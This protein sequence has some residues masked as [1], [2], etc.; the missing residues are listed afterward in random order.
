METLFSRYRNITILVAVLFAQVLTL[1]V[2][3]RRP[4][5]AGEGKPVRLI[6]VWAVTLVTPLEKGVVGANNFFGGLWHNYFWLRGVRKENAELRE[7]M[8]RMRLEEIRLV[9]DAAQ[10]RRLQLLLS[11]K[12]QFVSQT[13]A[14]QV[15]GTGG[16]ELSRT[17][18]IDKGRD[19]GL[20]SDM[21]VIAPEGIVGKIIKVYSGSSLVLLINDAS[22]GAGAILS[23]SRLQAI[24]NGTPSG[25]LQL[26][27]VMADEKIEVGDAVITSGG[28][29]VFPKGLPIGTVTQVSQGPDFFL[30]IHVKPAA[31]IARLEEVLVITKII[32]KPVDPNTVPSGPIRA[33]DILAERLPTLA[34][35]ASNINSTGIPLTTAEL[36]ARERAAK[37]AAAAVTTPTTTAPTGSAAAAPPQTKPANSAASPPPAASGTTPA[38]PKVAPKTAPKS[39]TASPTPAAEPPAQ[40]PPPA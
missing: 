15:I 25:E 11:F 16:S 35:G 21:A 23:R 19:D 30:N 22:S 29:R 7:Q 40:Q 17:V 5:E 26:H 27:N 2:Q 13:V 18:Y 24:L 38:K 4:P 12:E 34:P 14:A 1:A 28:D 9:Q 6:R 31:Q 10:G 3:V 39:E 36:A 20:K 33:A 32:E 8:E 37:K